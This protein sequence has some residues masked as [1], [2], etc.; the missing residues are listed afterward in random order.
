MAPRKQLEARIRL[1]Q[2][3]QWLQ[4]LEESSNCAEKVHQNNIRR[5][6]RRDDDDGE[7]N[8]CFIFSESW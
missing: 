5:R 3:G 2:E 4:L 1:F 7:G 8:P 6:R